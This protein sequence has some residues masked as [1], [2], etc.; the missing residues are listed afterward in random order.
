MSKI[1]LSGQPT[2]TAT[3][4]LVAP[5]TNT[6]RTVTLPDQSGTAFVGNA[7]GA[8]PMFACRAWVNFDGTRD[9]TGA[10]STANTARFI[11]ASGN[12]SSVMRTGVGRYTINFAIPLPDGDYAVGFSGARDASV[13]G[14]AVGLSN[15][16]AQSA[17]NFG[18]RA[19]TITNATAIDAPTIGIS[20]FR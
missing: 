10:V 9:S 13:E 5:A 1:A 16:P 19:N 3:F 4:D 14:T 17:T 20:V 15:D 18:I 8:A 6:N 12:V 11:R 7:P 2:G